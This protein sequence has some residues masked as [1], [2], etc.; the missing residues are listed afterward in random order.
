M[1][2]AIST[3]DIIDVHKGEL[4]TFCELKDGTKLKYDDLNVHFQRAVD[5]TAADQQVIYSGSIT[6]VPE[7]YK[8]IIARMQQ[9]NTGHGGRRLGA[10]R[11]PEAVDAKGQTARK[12]QSVYCTD[13][14]IQ[15]L[16][17]VLKQKRAGQND[18]T[19]LQVFEMAFHCGSCSENTEST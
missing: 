15:F 5:I 19:L 12:H 1:E 4:Y 17:E 3:R 11:K 10:G 2:K 13:L 8:R 6:V 7:R 18:M 14:E 16:R 9:V